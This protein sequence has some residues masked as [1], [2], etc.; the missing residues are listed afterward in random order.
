MWFQM[1][2][3]VWSFLQLIF[4]LLSYGKQQLLL[5]ESLWILT[6]FFRIFSF[7]FLERM[8]WAWVIA[9]CL[10]GSPWACPH[11]SIHCWGNWL[12]RGERPCGH[13]WQSWDHDPGPV[14]SL[15]SVLNSWAA[16][17]AN[18]PF[19]FFLNDWVNYARKPGPLLP[20]EA[21]THA[22]IRGGTLHL[23]YS[24]FQECAVGCFQRQ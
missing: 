1:W 19:F 3:F 13:F 22:V 11:P 12:W 21:V 8:S 10:E 18:I 24:L 16:L 20:L 6:F 2:D 4:S 5:C 15:P 9:C 23:L 17:P 14:L 7:D